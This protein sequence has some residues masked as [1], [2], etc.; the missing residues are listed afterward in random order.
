MA[1]KMKTYSFTADDLSLPKDDHRIKGYWVEEGG[2][3][4]FVRDGFKCGGCNWEC[5]KLF[6]L[7]P[8]REKAKRQIE[9]GDIGMCGDCFAEFM[10]ENNN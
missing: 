4:D 5:D 7:A 3:R 2:E 6:A 8:S 1:A 10:A 9:A